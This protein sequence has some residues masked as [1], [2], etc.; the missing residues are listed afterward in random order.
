MKSGIYQILNMETGK[1]YVGS[2][3]NIEKRIQRHKILLSG[4][5]HINK[6]LQYSWNKHGSESFVFNV[7]EI[8]Q[9]T[10]E[11]LIQREQY[12]ID[13]FE[14]FTNGYNLVPR[15]GTTLGHKLS[16]ETKKRLSEVHKGK[17]LSEEAKKKLRI[18]WQKFWDLKT[19]EERKNPKHSL[20]MKK[21]WKEGFIRVSNKG[22]HWKLE[23]ETKK[24][25]SETKK[26]LFKEGKLKI[27]DKQKI[28]LSNAMRG[29]HHSKEFKQMMSE[30]FSGEGNPYYGR[31]HSLEILKKMSDAHKGYVTP[32][33]TKR[34]M[35]ESHKGRRMTE[36]AKR[37]MSETR[38]KNFKEG[39]YNNTYSFMKNR[40]HSKINNQMR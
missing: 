27:S 10:K 8:V 12:W 25:M 24:K 4:N 35:S 16:E 40:S 13:H 29:K 1:C 36:E 34:K 2:S 19:P 22:K 3:V 18:A 15:A 38:K 21:L 9:P 37:K 11:L 14:S 17:K 20:V 28:L 23:D 39:K 32:E 6:K 30:K 26:R 7:L 31:K 5:K 33:E